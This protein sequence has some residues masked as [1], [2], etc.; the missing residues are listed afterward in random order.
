MGDP[1]AVQESSG[2][3]LA[4]GS[5]AAS[6]AADGS[7]RPA[8]GSRNLLFTWFRRQLQWLTAKALGAVFAAPLGLKLLFQLL[9]R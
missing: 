9:A 2:K 5:G 3:A 4:G 7:H 8:G 6:A 1:S